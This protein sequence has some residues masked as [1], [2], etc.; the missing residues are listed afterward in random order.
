VYSQAA[1]NL[2]QY[3]ERGRERGGSHPLLTCL[4]A[5]A[6]A[7]LFPTD[8]RQCTARQ[9]PACNSKTYRIGRVAQAKGSNCQLL[10]RQSRNHPLL[11]MYSQQL[12][13]CDHTA[14][15]AVES[16]AC[17]NLAVRDQP[18][19]S[20]SKNCN[21]RRGRLCMKQRHS[22]T[23]L[24]TQKTRQHLP[25][26]QL[27][28]LP[29]TVNQPSLPTS[30]TSLQQPNYLYSLLS[31]APATP[32][33]DESAVT[34]TGF[35]AYRGPPGPARP[36]L[37]TK[38]LQFQYLAQVLNTRTRTKQKCTAVTNQPH[39]AATHCTQTADSA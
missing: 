2:Q 28:H 37:Q 39:L 34:T 25:S 20:A 31:S 7:V 27:S 14:G 35:L 4:S 19:T 17:C 15:Q 9:L 36:H 26:R 16:H 10:H 1:P 21:R 22:P 3:T 33:A 12:L 24:L 13:A 11:S 32:T 38:Q 30:H 6:Q 5:A 8:C 18:R 29:A 23:Q